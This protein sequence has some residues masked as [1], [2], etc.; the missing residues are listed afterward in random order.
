MQWIE[1]I[2]F[3]LFAL[4]LVSNGIQAYS[5][6]TTLKKISDSNFMMRPGEFVPWNWR[7]DRPWQSGDPSPAP[8]P[9]LYS[10]KCSSQQC[11][12]RASD[13]IQ[14]GNAVGGYNY[15]PNIQSCEIYSQ[16]GIN[17]NTARFI[18]NTNLTQDDPRYS[19]GYALTNL[20]FTK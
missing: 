6:H 13:F 16:V 20:D 10:G 7:D 14:K 11:Q 12:E 1:K 18:P 9:L 2:I 5:M 15:R 3:V 19:L 8:N 17:A 4:L